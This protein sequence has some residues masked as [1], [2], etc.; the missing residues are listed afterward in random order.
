MAAL[1]HDDDSILASQVRVPEHVVYRDFAGETV[2][3]N[4][5][6]GMYHGLNET[7]GRMLDVIQSSASVAG[8]IDDLVTELGQPREVIARDVVTLCRA[9]DDRGLIERRAGSTD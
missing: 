3:L 7:A 6:S 4:L 5:Q 1:T 9:L 8:A 2:V